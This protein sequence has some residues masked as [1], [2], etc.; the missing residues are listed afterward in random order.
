MIHVASHRD[1]LLSGILMAD[2]RVTID[3]MLDAQILTDLLTLSGCLTGIAG[4]NPGDELVGLSRAAL[5]AGAP[6]VITTL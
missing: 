4:Q 5:V 2:G 3:D 6:S 1:P